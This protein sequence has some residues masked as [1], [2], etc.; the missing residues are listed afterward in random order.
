MSSGVG[1][2]PPEDL[3]RSEVAE[4]LAQSGAGFL[5]TRPCQNVFLTNG[6]VILTVIYD[7]QNWA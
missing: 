4:E 5:W 3:R 7:S 2:R 6:E 1:G